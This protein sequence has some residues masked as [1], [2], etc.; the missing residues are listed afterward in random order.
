MATYS[1]IVAGKISWTEAPGRLHSLGLKRGTH[2]HTHTQHIW[3][4]VCVYVGMSMYIFHI[5][6]YE[7]VYVS[8]ICIIHVMYAVL[9]FSCMC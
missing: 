3:I 6:V 1:S 5:Y 4:C 7:C 2:T 8:Y 9:V